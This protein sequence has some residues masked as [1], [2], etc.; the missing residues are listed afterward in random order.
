MP[1]SQLEWSVDWTVSITLAALTQGIYEER[2]GRAALVALLEARDRELC[3]E[4]CDPWDHHRKGAA[5]D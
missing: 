2:L 4:L 3:H 5:T 1:N